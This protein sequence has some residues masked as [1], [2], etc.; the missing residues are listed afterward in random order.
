MTLVIN[1]IDYDLIRSKISKPLFRIT[2]DWDEAFRNVCIDST[3]IKGNGM[4]TPK[5]DTWKPIAADDEAIKAALESANI[6]VLMVALVHLTGDM[7]II[8]AEI[9]PHPRHLGEIYKKNAGISEEQRAEV[10]VRALEILKAYRDGGCKLPKPP[11]IDQVGEMMDFLAGESLPADYGEFLMGELSLDGG[12]P[13]GQPGIEDIPQDK[14]GAFHVIVIG[15]GMSGILAAYRL[16]QAGISY[17]VVEKNSDV[18]G[19][20]FENSYPGCRVDNPNHIYSYSFR[21]KDWPKYYSPQKVLL[22]Y[23]NECA[24]EFGIRPNIRFNTSVEWAEFDEK[25]NSWKVGV[26][27]NDGMVQT[28]EANAIISSVGQLNRPRLPDIPGRDKFAGIS[29]HSARW[30]HEHDL[31]AKRIAVIGTGASAF[32]LV[33][34][35][36]K[37]AGEVFVFQRSPNWIRIDPVY[38]DDV[39]KGVHWLLNHVPFYAKWFRVFLFWHHAEGVLAWVKK[40]ESW[41]DQTLSISAANDELRAL[42]IK[43][44]SSIVGD[45][46][47]LLKKCIPQYP[48]AGR[49]MLLDNG[50]WLKTLKRSNVHLITDPIAAISENGLI[51]ESGENYEVGGIIYATGFYPS[52]M[53]WPMKIKGLGGLDLQKHWDGDPRA[54]LGITVPKFPNLFCMY[55]PNTNIVANGSIIFFSE[56]EMRYI[57]GCIKLLLETGHAALEPKGSVHDTYNRWVDEGNLGMAW[58]T[59]NVRSWYKNRVGRVTQNWPFTLLEFW[60]RTQAPNKSDYTLL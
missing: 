55:G 33:P 22:E 46:E 9:G 38:H 10:C 11:T 6:R 47:D 41:P 52:R 24:D 43:N 3:D 12:D 60:K 7:N 23:F 17:T 5:L 31:T 37:R 21:P 29:F 1:L 50:T 45:D 54:F 16:K 8:R 39:P 15:S 49:R 2:A 30:G 25:T 42:F 58:G 51:T 27:G 34:E 26:K 20:W 53:L 28:L 13:Y 36:A 57:L 32:Q 4:A 14:R 59:K 40:D 18:G 19:T 48:P 56:C 44:I 35:I